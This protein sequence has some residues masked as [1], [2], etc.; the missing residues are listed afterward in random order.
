[1]SK[2]GYEVKVEIVKD[3]P[4]K[5][6]NKYMDQ[7][8]FGIARATL[9]FTNTGHHFP[10]RTGALNRASMSEGVVYEGF[11][12]YHLGARGVEYAPK[13]WNYENVNWTNKATFP[14]WYLTE[15]QKDKN[16]IVQSAIKNVLGGLK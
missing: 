8:V 16:V 2:N 6:I 5:E 7:V 12:T 15:F 1:M 14:K 9:D 13:V 4:T 11:A 10:Y 3:I